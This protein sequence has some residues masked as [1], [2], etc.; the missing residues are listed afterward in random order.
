MTMK[1]KKLHD[2][3]E[4]SCSMGLN[5]KSKPIS[6][7]HILK[8]F[9]LKSLPST[10]EKEIKTKGK[11]VSKKTKIFSVVEESNLQYQG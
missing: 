5:R 2:L 3:S 4:Y 8:S 10:L 11:R 6:K 1:S 9:P 7:V